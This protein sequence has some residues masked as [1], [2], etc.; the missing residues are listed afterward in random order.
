MLTN[1]AA[2]QFAQN[3]R[4]QL[5]PQLDTP[6]VKRIDAPYLALYK[7]FVFVQGNQGSQHRRCQLL[8]HYCI[9]W[10]V[11]A[12]HLVRCQPCDGLIIHTAIAEFCFDLSACFTGHQRLCLRYAISQQHGVVRAG[13]ITTVGSSNKVSRNQI[14]ALMNQLEKRVLTIGTGL[15]PKYCTSCIVHSLIVGANL[16]AIAFHIKLL[17]VSGKPVQILIIRRDDL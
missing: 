1:R 16:L 14:S 17:Q 8:D 12:E 4:G 11:A 10:T 6:L 13:L 15:S 2:L 9:G 5:F 3:R 7:H